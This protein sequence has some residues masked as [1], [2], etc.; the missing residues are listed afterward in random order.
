MNVKVG[1]GKQSIQA[2][3]EEYQREH[4]RICLI[5]N[6]RF[7]S[8]EVDLEFLDELKRII[9]DGYYYVDGVSLVIDTDTSISREFSKKFKQWLGEED[10]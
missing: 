7:S 9:K 2:L 5:D 10:E 6:L 8:A 4:E 1:N 3:K